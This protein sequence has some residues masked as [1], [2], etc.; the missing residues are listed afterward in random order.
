MESKEKK[1]K[2][3]EPDKSL[4]SDDLQTARTAIRKLRRNGK[5]QDI[6]GIIKAYR[7]QKQDNIRKDI[8]AL[9]CD[10]DIAGSSDY[11][12]DAIRDPE[13][14]A[15]VAELLCI[16]WES[17]QD[18]TGHL[19]FFLAVFLNSDYGSSIEAFTIIENIFLDYSMPAE[20]IQLA[21]DLI[22][23]GFSGLSDDKQ[24]LAL[25]LLDTLDNKKTELDTSL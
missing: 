11:F 24:K 8:H 3:D 12:V 18:F 23:K 9:L 17:R 13:N 16:C 5:L 2:K 19:E 6:P 10:I 20:K 1:D 15:I 21:I 25:V 22:K 4:L 14:E 7:M